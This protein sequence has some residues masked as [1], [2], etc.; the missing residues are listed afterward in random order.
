MVLRSTVL[1]PVLGPV[2]TRVRVVRIDTQVGWNDH[3]TRALGCLDEE[4][5][6]RLQ[7][8]DATI[9][10]ELWLVAVQHLAETPTGE[11]VI[12]LP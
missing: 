7:Q 1:P 5:M 11:N 6:P 8:R 12:D 3:A 10:L 2:I 9:V 4:G